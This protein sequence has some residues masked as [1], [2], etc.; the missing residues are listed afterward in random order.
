[1]YRYV[2]Q[3]WEDRRRATG[4]DE[5]SVNAAVSLVYRLFTELRFNSGAEKVGLRSREP[6]N[7]PMRPRPSS[8]DT[9]FPFSLISLRL[10]TP[11]TQYSSNFLVKTYL[12]LGVKRGSWGTTTKKLKKVPRRFEAI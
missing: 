4:R 5:G 1:M 12:K 8:V 7:G 11:I 10:L 2:Q 9:H 6:E 3:L